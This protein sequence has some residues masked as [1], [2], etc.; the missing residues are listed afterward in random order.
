MIK[1]S[2]TSTDVAKAAGVSRTTVSMIL[3]N[4]ASG[5]FPEET[6]ARVIET[7]ATLGYTP[8]SAARMLVRGD[9]E[10]IGFVISDPTLLVIDAFVPR[11]MLGISEY[12]NTVGY[13]VLLEA[14]TDPDRTTAYLDLVRSKR[15]DGLVVLNPK[16]DDDALRKLIRGG[17]PVVL[18]GSA[19][20]A[21]EYVVACRNGS[22]MR[23]LVA[24]LVE[25]G[26]SRIG[27]VTL[28]P[29]GTSGADHRLSAYRRALGE[30]GLAFD[31]KLVCV[32]AYSA[33]SGYRAMS[34][35]LDRNT[36]LTAVL[37]ANDTL[38]LGAMA[39]VRE[40]GL[41]I[42]D[43]LSMSGFDDLQFAPF[44][45]PPLTSVRNDAVKQGRL[46]AEKLIRL[47]RGETGVARRTNV[48]SEVVFRASF[49][50]APRRTA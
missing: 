26:H 29:P 27:H 20:E 39:A 3:N 24:R 4:S 48:Q 22:P 13:R 42:P 18:L 6:R 33:E 10:T 15:I 49:G 35:L 50:P 2:V 38:A 25:L 19:G 14:V 1:R 7:A 32:G 31:P 40:R 36:D 21:D 11:Y 16:V 17:F 28:S 34:E 5:N 41:R 43:D 30:A 46:A 9:T 12:A 47:L 37:V 45:D 23:E 8:N 44:A